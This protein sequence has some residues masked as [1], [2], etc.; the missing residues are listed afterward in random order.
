VAAAPATDVVTYENLYAHEAYWPYH[1]ELTES[2]KPEGYPGEQ[3]GWGIGVLVRVEP[4]GDLRMDFGRFG[5]Y[6]VPARVT[7]VVEE[8]NRI[9]L[10]ERP[11]SEPNFVLAVVN[12]L[13]DPTAAPIRYLKPRDVTE[14]QAFLLVAVDPSTD[15]FAEIAEAFAPLHDRADVMPVLL[16]QGRRDDGAVLKRCQAVGWRDP[17][18]HSRFS[19]GFTRSILGEDVPLPNVLLQSPEG[20]VLY[21]A[22]W[23]TGT[24]AAVAAVI[25]DE[26]GAAP[27]PAA[28]G[29]DASKA[30]AGH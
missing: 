18:A 20:R 16:P 27:Q 15:A 3:L 22:P 4:E 12:K 6:R 7:N 5:K 9:R 21:G 8:A 14:V 19:N 17:F 13:L 1:V 30:T 28:D 26:L 11:K 10:G 24:A 29:Q 23:A 25:A 2:W